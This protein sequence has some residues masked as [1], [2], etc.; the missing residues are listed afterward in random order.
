VGQEAALN[1]GRD[2]EQNTEQLHVQTRDVWGGLN[3]EG[4]RLSKSLKGGNE[5][6]QAFAC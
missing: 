2:T 6:M 3:K 4:S 1:P 5:K